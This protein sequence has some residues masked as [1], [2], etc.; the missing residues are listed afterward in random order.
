MNVFETKDALF[1]AAAETIEAAL[2][3]SLKDTG[4][5]SLLLSGGST[6]A[7]TYKLLSNTSLDWKN[8]KVGLV[9]ERWVPDTHAA[10]NAKL[11]K[12]SLL[13]NA[14]SDAE[15]IPM[16]N[17]AVTAEDGQEAL[18]KAYAP[19]ESPDVVVLGMGPDGHTASWFPESNGL[20]DAMAEDQS[21]IVKAIDASGCAVAGDHTDRMTITLPV[22]VRAKTILLLM[23]GTSKREVFE[24]ASARLP[25]HALHAVLG[26]K[27][28]IYWAP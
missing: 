20:D 9:D 3:E 1:S 13:L 28:Q 22:T 26:R 15:F 23:N 12:E 5:A 4:K 24:N 10:S 11:A 18:E 25:I 7:P 19:F 8:V 17:G 6:P 14:A 2:S 27:L 21:S 16:F